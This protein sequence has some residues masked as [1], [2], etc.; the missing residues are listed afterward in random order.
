MCSPFRSRWG[1]AWTRRRNVS[2]WLRTSAQLRE[3][4]CALGAVWR[5]DVIDHSAGK[6]K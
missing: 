1:E 4:A 2:E 5:K 3:S 6:A